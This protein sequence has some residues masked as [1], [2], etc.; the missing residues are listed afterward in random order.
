MQFYLNRGIVNGVQVTPAADIDRLESP[1]TTWAAQDG[2]KIGYGLGNHWSIM[3]GFIYHGHGGAIPG[4]STNVAYLPDHG[5]GFVFSINAGSGEAFSKLNKAICGYITLRF[6]RPAVPAPGPLPVDAADYTGWYEPIA[7]RP[8]IMHFLFRLTRLSLVQVHDGQM[9]I[10]SYNLGIRKFL[11]VTGRLFR[12]VPKAG[13][14][15]PVASMVLL[16][17][18]R[19]IANSADTLVRIPSWLA[20]SEI[21][22]TG[23]FLVAIV[24]IALYAPLWLIGGLMKRHPRPAERAM[25]LC[26]LIAV[27]SLTAF[28]RTITHASIDSVQRFGNLTV[29]SGTVFVTT[30]VFAVATLLGAWSVATARSELVR[31]PVLWFSAIVSVALVIALGYLTYWGIIGLRTW[32]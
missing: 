32:A 19:F 23:F 22:L 24:S 17:N 1:E 3:D 18:K 28:V 21:L 14:P 30:I 10:L 27:L 11:P 29:W 7:V 13:P 6:Q 12:F 31:R 25:L 9:A 26:P 15:D 2:L 4:G 20:Y 16:S 8:E 5:V